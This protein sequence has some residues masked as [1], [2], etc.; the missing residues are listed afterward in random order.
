MNTRI[1]LFSI[2][3]I[4]ICLGCEKKCKESSHSGTGEIIAN[5]LIKEPFSEIVRDD[6]IYV[7]QA[8]SQNVFDLEVS[9]DGGSTY[10]SINFQEYTLLGRYA[11]GQGCDVYF[12][13][14][15]TKNEEGKKTYYNI[16]IYQCG[17]CKMLAKSMN[18]V[19]VPKI[20]ETD[21][22]VF[23]VQ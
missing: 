22:V 13:R 7:I 17:S 12:D 19:L 4:M 23:I 8:D 6:N 11:A 18:W 15:V 16:K 5:A 20:S 14:N 9:F 21:T 3:L 1:L 10:D 2:V